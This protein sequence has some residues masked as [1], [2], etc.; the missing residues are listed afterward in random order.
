MAV[1][2]CFCHS[3]GTQV[4]IAYAKFGC[5]QRIL[6]TNL[7]RGGGGERKGIL[8]GGPMGPGSPGCPRGPLGPGGPGGPGGPWMPAWPCS[9][10]GL[11]EQ[12]LGRG[13]RAVEQFPPQC[14]APSEGPAW[15]PVGGGGGVMVVTTC[16]GWW[17]QGDGQGSR[18]PG[19]GASREELLSE[20]W[21]PE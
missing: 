14:H 10:C 11:W 15:A 2:R 9:P 13:P 17:Q 1:Q 8:T 12:V 3:A 21:S 4:L 20:P 7:R 16:R 6:E 18:P 5:F 19:G